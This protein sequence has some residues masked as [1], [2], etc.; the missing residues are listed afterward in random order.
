M[1]FN[2]LRLEF[3]KFKK[4][5]VV[6]LLAIFYV[7]FFPLGYLF[8]VE[9]QD[10]LPSFIKSRATMLEFP[11][12][13]NYMGYGGSWLA[14][15]FLG[16]IAAYIIGL[17]YQYKTFR[18]SIINGMSRHDFFVSKF[19]AIGTIALLATAYYA[20]VCF[21]IGFIHT[22]NASSIFA[23]NLVMIPRYFLMCLGYMSFAALITLLAKRSGLAVFVYFSYV[24]II[25]HLLKWAIHYKIFPN[26]TVNY[27]PSNVIED[28][29]PNPMWS[30]AEAIPQKE[31]DF[32]FVLNP[33]AATIATII[34]IALFTFASYR[35]ITRSDV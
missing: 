34:Y 4:S 33:Q 12:V 25:E 5:P 21:V 9:I 26:E 17:E 23:G 18:Q 3:H 7:V 8:G 16:I 1:M 24:M 10:N 27:Y 35:I 6:R 20:I 15:F 14:F 32:E 13:W 2:Y 31:I 28:L 19:I 11:D 30:Y 29:T 22:E